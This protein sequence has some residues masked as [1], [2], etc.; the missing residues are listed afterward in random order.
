MPTETSQ[1]TSVVS[2][3]SNIASDEITVTNSEMSKNIDN[4]ETEISSANVNDISVTS[5]LQESTDFTVDTSRDTVTS[6]SDMTTTRTAI[7]FSMTAMQEQ[8]L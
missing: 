5:E 2:V 3:E 6:S 4:I 1:T 8:F 7:F